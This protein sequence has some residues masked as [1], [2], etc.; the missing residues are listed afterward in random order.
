MSYVCV[1]YELLILL[2]ICSK[3]PFFIR[4]YEKSNEI[5]CI[6]VKI[7]TSVICASLAAIFATKNSTSKLRCH[8]RLYY[9]LGEPKLSDMLQPK[10]SYQR[11]TCRRQLYY[12]N[13]R[14]ECL[15][16]QIQKKV[17]SFQMTWLLYRTLFHL[18]APFLKI[19]KFF[20][21]KKTTQIYWIVPS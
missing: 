14:K 3:S 5:D 1:I 6:V 7:L 12:T 2:Q 18:S 11:N 19:F 10:Y 21:Q 16:T 13:E 20:S 17:V 4:R 9:V 8:H 15:L